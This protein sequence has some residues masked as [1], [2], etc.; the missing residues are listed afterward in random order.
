MNI[1]ALNITGGIASSSSYLSEVKVSDGSPIELS[2][3]LLS[4]IVFD[5]YESGTL[6]LV[7]TVFPIPVKFEK[8][9]H[10]AAAVSVAA[11]DMS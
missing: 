10:N 6:A 7:S 8:E 2:D 11:E 5:E 9:F 4:G 1:N 3:N